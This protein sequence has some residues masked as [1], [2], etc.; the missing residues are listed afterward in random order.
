MGKHEMKRRKQLKQPILYVLTIV[1]SVLLLLLGRHYAS[2]EL[3]ILNGED[4]GEIIVKARIIEITDRVEEEYQLDQ[5][6][7]M[8]SVTIT[9]TAAILDGESKGETVTGIQYLDSL[10]STGIT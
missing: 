5:N 6:T 2:Q 8:E 4:Y 1:L 10:Y 9:Y 3:S 7:T